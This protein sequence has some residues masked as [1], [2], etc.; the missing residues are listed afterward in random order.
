[1]IWI[2]MIDQMN[3]WILVKSGLACVA[4]AWKWWAQEK[5]GAREGDTRGEREPHPWRVSLARAR[6]FSLSP[7]T[8]KRLL[9]RLRV[10]SSGHLICHDPSDLGSLILIRIISKERTLWSPRKWREMFQ[11]NTKKS[12]V[13]QEQSRNCLNNQLKLF[14]MQL[15]SY[16]KHA[17]STSWANLCSFNGLPSICSTYRSPAIKTIMSIFEYHFQDKESK[18]TEKQASKNVQLVLQHCCKTMSWIVI[19]IT[20]K[21][22]SL[23]VS[24][25]WRRTSKAALIPTLRRKK[26]ACSELLKRVKNSFHFPGDI[27]II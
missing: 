11:P 27:N 16:I 3:R 13:K 21:G 26:L 9:R 20:Y 25:I 18:G 10:D 23:S 14:K 5:T 17:L 12:Y 15:S 4:G 22:R 8:S 1:M 19:Y 24:W 6:P 7:T 2:R